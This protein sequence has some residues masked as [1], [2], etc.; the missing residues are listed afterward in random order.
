MEY[1]DKKV[2]KENHFYVY[3]LRCADNTLYTGWTVNLAARVAR[4][5]TGK[6]AKYTRSRLPVI[7]V[8][9]EECAD[10]KSARRRELAI[11]RLTRAEKLD[12]VD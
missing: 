9:H 1:G 5:N 10:E 4:H 3:I 12:L 6:G 2:K 11:K 7:L 8:Y